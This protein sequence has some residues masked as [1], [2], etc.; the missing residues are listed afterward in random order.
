MTNLALGC[1][2]YKFLYKNIGAVNFYCH[3]QP[4]S[5]RKSIWKY[6]TSVKWSEA[7]VSFSMTPH[8]IL[9]YSNPAELNI[10]A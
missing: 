1:G 2:A 10:S 6:Y 7:F 5:F 4:I 9:L 3:E 8:C